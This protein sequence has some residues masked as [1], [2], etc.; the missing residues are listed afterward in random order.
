MTMTTPAI[1]ARHVLGRAQAGD[2]IEWAV[3]ALASGSDSPNLRILAGLDHYCPGIEQANDDF[4]V[5]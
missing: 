3:E 4:S 5:I 1:Q 2:Y